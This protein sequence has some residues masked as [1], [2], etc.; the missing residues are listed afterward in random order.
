M[1]PGST[2]GKVVTLDLD[3]D[4]GFDDGLI[5][6]GSMEV[7]ISAMSQPTHA[8]VLRQAADCIRAG[9]SAT[10][11]IQV[12]AKDGLEEHRIRIE[13]PPKLIIAGGGHLGRALAEAAVPLGFHITV[14]D[15]RQEFANPDRFGP[16]IESVTGNIAETL[17]GWPI[18]PNA[19]IV[20][21]TRGHKHDEQA[22]AAVL[23]SPAKYIGMIGSRRKI[24]V[25]FD[26]LKHDGAAQEQLDRVYA[27]IG[28]PIKA[29][30]PE[31]IAVSIAAELISTRRADHHV[32]SAVRTTPPLTP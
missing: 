9:A 24:A 8:Q 20:I 1:A 2:S 22:L 17:A 15:D 23:D 7:A 27:P 25:I 29:L 4:F 13:A 28:L 18:D 3:H 10:L 26:D 11:Q 6:G 31:E 32:G 14:I 16:P 30:T 12:V 5:C 19:Y 21:V